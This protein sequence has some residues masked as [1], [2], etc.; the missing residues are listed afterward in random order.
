[1]RTRW[2]FFNGEIVPESAVRVSPFDHGFLYGDGIFEGIRA[3]QGR[4]FKLAEHLA[5][6]YASA[7]SLLLTIPYTPEEMANAVVDT[8]K[9]NNLRDAYIRLVVSRGPGDLGLDPR[10]CAEPTVIIIADNIQLYPESFYEQGLPVASSAVRRPSGDVLNPQIKSLNY[11]NSILAKI[12]AGQRGVPEMILLNQWGHVV[13]GT[14]DNVFI[15]RQGGLV[16]PPLSAG[17]LPGV[18]RQTVMDLARDHGILVREENFTLHELYNA[19]E[20][21]LT[22]TAAEVVPVVSCDGR[23]IGSGRPGPL[24]REIRDL[25]MQYAATHGTDI[26]PNVPVG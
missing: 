24:T 9:A 10:N 3:Y 21:F 2:M 19:D 17:I 15:V 7:K 8:V 22:G 25:F 6:L 16:T 5:R 23:T 4:V 13:E 1:M 26:Y 18:T 20:C 11:L 12:E 14:G